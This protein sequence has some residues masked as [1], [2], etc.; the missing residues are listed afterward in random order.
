MKKRLQMLKRRK[1]AMLKMKSLL[2]LF[3]VCTMLASCTPKQF[4]GKYTERENSCILLEHIE[5]LPDRTVLEKY[6]SIRDEV[7]FNAKFIGEDT[8]VIPEQQ[9]TWYFKLRNDTLFEISNIDYRCYLV[10]EKE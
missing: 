7:Q 9:R 10:K 4:V 1:Q 5:V 3:F 8:L 6:I 2:P